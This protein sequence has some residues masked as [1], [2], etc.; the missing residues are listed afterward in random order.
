MAS[1]EGAKIQKNWEKQSF[2]DV[3]E[4]TIR[5]IRGTSWKIETTIQSPYIIW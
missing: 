2:R 4:N 1:P 3:N 5:A